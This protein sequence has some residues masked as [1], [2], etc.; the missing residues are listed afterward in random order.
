V[1]SLGSEPRTYAEAI[2]GVCKLYVE[3]PLVCVSGVTG[4]DLKKRIEAIMS[5]RIGLGL[6]LTKKLLLASAGAAALVGPVVMGVVIGA[7]HASALR[8]QSPVAAQTPAPVPAVAQTV[9]A[10]QT[11]APNVAAQVMQGG[12]GSTTATAP[13]DHRMLTLLFD[14]GAMTSDEQARARQLAIQFVQNRMEPN[15]VMSVMMA[16]EGTL[17]VVQDFTGDK[18]L[19]A[20]VLSQ[21]GGHGESSDASRLANLETAARM[22]GAVSGKKM[23]LYFSSGAPLRGGS[24]EEAQIQRAI[25]AARVSNV[26]F[27]VID[28]SGDLRG[29]VPQDQR[30]VEARQKFGTTGGAMSRTYIRYGPPDQVDDRGAQGQIWRYNY[31]ETFRSR[32][33]FEFPAANNPGGPHINW[34][35]PLAT[36]TGTGFP[37][38]HASFQTYP[39]GEVQIL[40]V[41]LDDFAG[42]VDLIGEV[43]RVLQTGEMQVVA[44]VRDMVTAAS[45]TYQANFLLQAGSYVGTV[46][47]R[48]HTTGR[49]FTETIRFEVK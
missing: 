43:K 37:G 18:A 40:S 25:D 47:L 4:A 24:A 2:L 16:S 27:F 28:V 39:A 49:Q 12:R 48:E 31:L 35:P 20:S 23:M 41:P 17:K 8:A 6:N 22:L 38:K 45:G 33:E 10:A 21:L 34:P 3:S 46:F 32:A 7:S 19:L 44:N 29:V 30:V 11:A 14:C 13:L 42:R 9:R 1:L 36:F 15:D 5:N 26:A